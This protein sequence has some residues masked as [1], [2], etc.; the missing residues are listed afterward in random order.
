MN[1]TKFIKHLLL[2]PFGFLLVFTMLYFWLKGESGGDIVLVIFSLIFLVV[3]S[4]A[5]GIATYSWEFKAKYGVIS[6]LLS[7]YLFA[8]LLFRLFLY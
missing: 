7:S 1:L 6:G 5:I 4:L 3:Y 2:L 8:Y